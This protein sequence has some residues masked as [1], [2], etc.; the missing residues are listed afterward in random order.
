MMPGSCFGGRVLPP[1][2]LYMNLR[3]VLF[4]PQSVFRPKHSM[5]VD[6]NASDEKYQM[7]S[8]LNVVADSGVVDV[9]ILTKAEM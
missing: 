7:T 2:E 9:F 5:Y 3:K 4:G 8:F 6:D 1:F